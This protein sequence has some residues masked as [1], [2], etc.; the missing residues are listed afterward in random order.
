MGVELWPKNQNLK[1]SRICFFHHKQ[2]NFQ[3]FQKRK[4]S[5]I[6]YSFIPHFICKTHLSSL[7]I[8]LTPHFSIFLLFYQKRDKKNLKFKK[9]GW[10][11]IFNCPK[12]SK[13]LKIFEI[14]PLE[15]YD[16][17]GDLQGRHC[18]PSIGVH[19]SINKFSPFILSYI[20]Q[21]CKFNNTW[22]D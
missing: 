13:K 4:K 3:Y 10:P 11:D 1:I 21:P 22:N 12:D 19:I 8:A 15:V 2:A 5:F 18:I 16:R 6:F 7:K 17:G 9:N 14:G 20:F